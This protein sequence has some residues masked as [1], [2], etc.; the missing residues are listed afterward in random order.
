MDLPARLTEIG[1]RNTPDPEWLATPP[2]NW[3]FPSAAFVDYSGDPGNIT[4]LNHT[5]WMGNVIP[6][7]TAGEV[8]DTKNYPLCFEYV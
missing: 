8:M 7:I 6:N 2:H 4:T 5:L 1:G 3:S